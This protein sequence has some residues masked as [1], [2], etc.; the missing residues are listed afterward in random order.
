MRA[1][2][3]L[4][5]L[6]PGSRSPRAWVLLAPGLDH[7]RAVAA[8]Q[9]TRLAVPHSVYGLVLAGRG[10]LPLPHARHAWATDRDA[11]R[12]A[13]HGCGGRGSANVATA[14]PFVSP[15][16]MMTSVTVATDASLLCST[17]SLHQRPR[18][19]LPSHALHFATT[20]PISSTIPRAR[21]AT[22][23][24]CPP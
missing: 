1:H 19:I 2:H 23:R 9:F 8:G 16:M 12:R 15:T 11:T 18:S 14:P 20:L 10:W 21:F 6:G 3:Q 7:A 13:S 24:S 5:S 17:A 4:P 22:N